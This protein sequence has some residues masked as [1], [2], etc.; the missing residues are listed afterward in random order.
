MLPI[1]SIDPSET[2]P[3]IELPWPDRRLHPN[4]RIHHM[5]KARVAKQSREDAAW[6]AKHAGVK[7]IKADALSV[8]IIFYP[9]DNRRRDVDGMLASLKPALDG[10]ADIIGVDDSKWQIALRKETPRPPFGAV[11]VEIVGKGGL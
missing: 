10:I 11:R 5:E 6:W 8:T 4:A 2:L 1:L 7:P 9:P 3:A